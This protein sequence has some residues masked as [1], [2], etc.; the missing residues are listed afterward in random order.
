MTDVRQRQYEI[1]YEIDRS[2]CHNCG[3]PAT[4]I[5]HRI[6]ATKVN[7][8]KYGKEI[9]DHN[10]NICPACSKKG[11]D[12]NDKANI[13]MKDIKCNRLVSLIKER[14]NERLS[15][16]EITEYING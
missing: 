10:M 3:L 6:A 13:G 9:I 2:V 16:A 5:C 12:C 7:Y 14:G 1:R 15:S 11:T 8:R 4:H